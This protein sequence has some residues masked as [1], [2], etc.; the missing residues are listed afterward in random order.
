M[1]FMT[2]LFS[3]Q[4]LEALDEKERQI[5]KEAILQQL[6]TSPEVNDI[7]KKLRKDPVSEGLAQP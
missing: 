5:L 7:L 2:L 4:E 3:A 1:A 6:Q